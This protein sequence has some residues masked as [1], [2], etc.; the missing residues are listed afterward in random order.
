VP[1]DLVVFADASMLSRMFQN[2]IANAIAYTP[3]GEV[4]I[5]ARGESGGGAAECWV[6]DTGAGIPYEELTTIFD[7][8]S[9]DASKAGSMGLGLALVKTFVEAHGGTVVAERNAGPGAT[10]RF[11]LPGP[12]ALPPSN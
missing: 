9:G 7:K 4:G 3:R 2:L 5:G 1:G 10:I 8:G 6:S 12:S 11:T